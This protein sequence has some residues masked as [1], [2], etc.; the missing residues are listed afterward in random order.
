MKHFTRRSFVRTALVL[1][2]WAGA[3]LHGAE[4]LLDAREIAARLPTVTAA[5]YPD[6]QVVLTAGAMRIRYAPDGTYE[7]WHEDYITILTEEGRRRYQTLSSHYTIPYQRGPQDCRIE[8]VAI[9]KPDG[10]RIELDVAAHSREMAD[11]SSMGQNIYSPNQ[12]IIRMNIPDLEV[13]DTLH[14]VMYDRIVHP[15]TRDLWAGWYVFEHDQ[16]ILYKYVEV[17]APSDRPLRSMAVKAPV[18]DTLRYTGTERDGRTLHRWE[19][20]DVPQAFPEP[21]MPPLYTVAQRVL[22]STSPD[23]ETVSR[24]YWN[25]SAPRLKPTPAIEAEVARLVADRTTR[26][27]RIEALFRF[28]SRHIR[29]LGVIKESEAPGYEPHDVGTTFAVRHGVCRDK[30]ALLVAMLR[31][32]GFEAY[33]TLIHNGPRK[34][35]EV[36]QPFFNHAIV[37]LREEDGRFLLMD[38]TDENTTTL[39]PAYLNN[40][41]YLVATPAGETLHT[42]PIDPATQNMM[43]IAT[44]GRADAAGRLRARTVLNFEGVNDNAYRS[45]LSRQRV[46][47]RQLFFLGLLRRTLPGARL[48]DF[49]LIPEDLGHVD[50]T[51]VVE[52]EYEADGIRIDGDNQFVLLAPRFGISVG[53]VNFALG[54]MG[55]DRRRYPLLISSASGVKE[56][57]DIDIAPAPEAALSLPVGPDRDTDDYT[58]RMHSSLT[59]GNRFRQQTEFRLNKVEYEPDAYRQLRAALRT[60]EGELRKR[61]VFAVAAPDSLGDARTLAEHVV[62]EIESPSR[63][64]ET[65]RIR[66]KILNYAGKKRYAEIKL[67]YNAGWEKAEIL[68]ARVTLA[69]GEVREI[70]PEEI[71]LMDQAW[72]GGAARY[73]AGHTLVASLPGVE[74]DSVLEYEIRRTRWDR[75]FFTALETFSGLEPC[76]FKSVVISAPKELA[77]RLDDRRLAEIGVHRT[78]TVEANGRIVRRWEARDLPR[79][80]REDHTPPTWVDQPVL[81]CSAGDWKTYA[82]TVAAALESAASRQPASAALAQTLVKDLETP[83]EKVAALRDFVARQVRSAGPNLGAMPLSTLTAADRTLADRYGNSA[84]RAVLLTALLRAV[85]FAPEW[86][87]A[88]SYPSVSEFG[89]VI[90]GFPQPAWFG[91][92]LLRIPELRD[93]A[94]GDV[95]LNDTDQYAVLGACAHEGRFALSLPQGALS[96]I[97]PRHRT[98]TETEYRIELAADGAARVRRTQLLH[99]LDHGARR[100]F[101]EELTP[102]KRR[103]EHSEMLAALAQS[104]V[105]DGDLETDFSAYPGR[106]VLTAR[107]PDFAVREDRRLYFE[108]PGSIENLLRLRSETRTRPLYS[109]RLHVEEWRATA[110]LPVGFVPAIRPPDYRFRLA[111]AT[112]V[113]V[114]AAATWNPDTRELAATQQA[115]RAAGVISAQ[116]YDALLKLESELQHTRRRFTLFEAPAG[117]EN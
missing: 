83:A 13:G 1:S 54:R 109:S 51:L 100:R 3:A 39:L 101:Y 80:L 88:G 8:A 31:V 52:M 65:R 90:E 76:D 59:N 116:D 94:A 67:D 50:R 45:Y 9:I 17:D 33:P 58:L 63:W 24:W 102:E 103:R 77:L 113:A 107:I 27:E 104:A 42:S 97:Q 74:P 85:G 48:L 99:G 110:Q 87:L 43:R 26:M 61:P 72:V 21:G 37:A 93:P 117:K 70:S 19:A 84:D 106:V 4:P 6:A 114:Q 29:Y 81:L 11:P 22:V 112:P 55:L 36:P 60:L 12:R 89:P 69:N 86:V 20:R 105:A 40:Q 73:P 64:T 78:E 91:A 18:G 79:I 115:Q 82:A 30:A 25:L 68:A 96:T 16:P 23:W 62:Y 7:Q 44:T 35:A 14:Y 28:V 111:G 49:R 75:P 38:P 56:Q 10:R 66:R 5:A 47:D 95:Y 2:V 32:A 92:V 41:S 71:N 15:R 57:I 34:D 53:M 98:R 108:M 46:E